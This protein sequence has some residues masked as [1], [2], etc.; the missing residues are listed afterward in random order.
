MRE[1]DVIITASPEF[2]VNSFLEELKNKDVSV[3]EWR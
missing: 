3:H 1:D 2:L